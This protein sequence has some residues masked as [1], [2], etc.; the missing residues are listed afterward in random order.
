M[1]TVFS[2][3]ECHGAEAE[4]GGSIAIG[5]EEDSNVSVD[6]L[7]ASSGRGDSATNLSLKLF[8]KYAINEDAK[9]SASASH[10]TTRYQEFNDL[11]RDTNSLTFNGSYDFGSVS[12]GANYFFINAKIDNRDFLTYQRVSTNLSAFIS[13]RWYARAA[14]VQGQK[15]FERQRGRSADI[16]GFETDLYFFHLGLKSY[17]NIGISSRGEDSLAAN[18]DYD[19]VSGKIRWVRRFD[20]AGK[21]TKAEFSIKYEDREYLS[22]SWGISE[23]RRDKRLRS[24][25]KLTRDA[26][27]GTKVELYAAYNDYSSNLPTADYDQFVGGVKILYEF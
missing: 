15:D 9:V 20:L 22:R 21:T 25:I 16:I 2:A 17:F 3:I 8:S 1:L 11:N 24:K 27:M 19:S 13:K 23:D 26:Y 4:F 10:S 12:A 18:Y 14:Y 5:W 6:E 7:E